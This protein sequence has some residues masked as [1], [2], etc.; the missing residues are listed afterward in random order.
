MDSKFGVRI[1]SQGLPGF[2]SRKCRADA[3]LAA[4][5]FQQLIGVQFCPIPQQQWLATQN[6]LC[7]VCYASDV[8]H[9]SLLDLVAMYDRCQWSLVLP[10]LTVTGT[11]AWVAPHP[12]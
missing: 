10:G 3:V 1:R 12:R 8:R 4:R 6:V 5:N 7:I 2:K 11:P 9:S